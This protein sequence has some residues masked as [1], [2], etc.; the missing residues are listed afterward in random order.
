[1]NC[2][3]YADKIQHNSQNNDIPKTFTFKT[4]ESGNFMSTGK[5]KSRLNELSW[6]FS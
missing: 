2:L 3:E 4:I 5:Q 1:M 6:L